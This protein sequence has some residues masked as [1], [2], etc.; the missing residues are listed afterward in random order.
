MAEKKGRS[1]YCAGA[2]KFGA[3]MIAASGLRQARH[4]P[5]I[6]RDDA[7]V[8]RRTDRRRLCRSSAI[9]SRERF[10]RLENPRPL[11]A[12]KL[13]QVYNRCQENALVRTRVL[14]ALGGT[15]GQT[16]PVA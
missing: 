3:H 4:A 15:A 7:E 9:E 16:P 8:Q 10:N 1:P 13:L 2:A 11:G 5:P 6:T 12:A 14:A